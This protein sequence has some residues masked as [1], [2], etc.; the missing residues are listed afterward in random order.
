MAKINIIFNDKA[1]SIDESVFAV[2]AAELQRHLSTTMSGSG[3]TINFGGVSYNIDSSKLAS[4]TSNLVSHLS[5]IAGSGS[6]VVIGGIEYSIDTNKV[7]SAIS[8]LETVLGNL[9]SGSGDVD[10]YI[11]ANEA[12]GETFYI[13]GTN[14]S[15]LNEEN[16]GGGQTAIID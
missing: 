15:L 12:G 11:E 13:I 9:N 8:D 5:K 10:F 7:N 1:Y 3:S 14:A 2:A 16:A 4:A 6:K